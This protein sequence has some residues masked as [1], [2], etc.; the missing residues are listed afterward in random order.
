MP[1]CK[2][3]ASVVVA[4][5]E[6]GHQIVLEGYSEPIGRGRY[7]LDFTTNPVTAIPLDGSSPVDG[8]SNHKV[9]CPFQN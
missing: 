7:A 4:Q 6:G 3:G 1:S 8:Y 2:C 9:R 5:T